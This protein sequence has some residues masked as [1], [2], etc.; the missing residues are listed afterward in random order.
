MSFDAKNII[1]TLK[2]QSK[3]NSFKP[4]N[5]IRKKLLVYFK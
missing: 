3:A 1:G 5:D 2:T 4:D